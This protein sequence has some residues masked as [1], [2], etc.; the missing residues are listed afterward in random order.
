[1]RNSTQW[2]T[3]LTS[4]AMAGLLTFATIAQ[5]ESGSGK[6]YAKQGQM[7]EAERAA[8]QEERLN[9]M[10]AKLGL[11]ESQKVQIQ[12]I[13]ANHKSQTKPMRK[14]MRTL[15]R[16]IQT[17]DPQSSEYAAKVNRQTAL[18]SQMQTYQA[19][20]RQQVASILTAEQLAMW[21]QMQSRSKGNKS[22]KRNKGS[23]VES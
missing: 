2:V 19:N 16:D 9:R 17:L 7:T 21:E 6:G 5:A 10:A 1:M 20:Q 11:N 22:G 3:I 15:K 8:K 18:K 23:Q 12:A 13:T 14:E 4:T